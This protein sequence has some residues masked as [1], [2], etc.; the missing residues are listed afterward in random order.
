MSRFSLT[1]VR[2]PILICVV[3]ATLLP[4]V[5]VT[6]HDFFTFADNMSVYENRQRPVR[7]GKLTSEEVI[8]YHPYQEL[9][10]R[11]KRFARGSM[12]S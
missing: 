3:L 4:Y 1:P 7:A 8:G 2:W 6:S 10:C 9:L 12:V 5:Q 11:G